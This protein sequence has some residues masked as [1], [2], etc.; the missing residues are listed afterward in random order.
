MKN[1]LV[2]V[3]SWYMIFRNTYILGTRLVCQNADIG[4]TLV[5]TLQPNVDKTFMTT[6]NQGECLVLASMFEIML[7]LLFT[8]LN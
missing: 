8:H 7:N 6:P 4:P 5:F 2:P 1:A 3:L